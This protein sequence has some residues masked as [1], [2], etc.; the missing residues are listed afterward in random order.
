MSD[1]KI[2]V[3]QR[4]YAAF[5]RGDLEALLTDVADDVDWAVQ[6]NATTAPWYGSYRGSAEVPR[7]FAAIGSSVEVSEFTPLSFT[8]NDTDVMTTVQWTFTSRATGRSGTEICTIGGAS[9]TAR[10][11]SC[12]GLVTASSP[13]RSCPGGGPHPQ[14]L[15][16]ALIKAQTRQLISSWTS[17]PTSRSRRASTT[18]LTRLA[19]PGPCTNPRDEVETGAQPATT[20][21]PSARAAASVPRRGPP[22]RADYGRTISNER[23]FR[24]NLLTE[25][26][27]RWKWA[28]RYEGQCLTPAARAPR[29]RPPASRSSR[30]ARRRRPTRHAR[31]AMT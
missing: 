1:P 15:R 22:G 16:R 21:S 17:A 5:G 20:S 29:P 31:V 26:A 8:S 9:P 30:P 23:H 13:R 28:L 12:G 11:C 27:V 10:S 19:L 7:F 6:P 2:D 3:I 18:S 25:S 14:P 24:S 4:M